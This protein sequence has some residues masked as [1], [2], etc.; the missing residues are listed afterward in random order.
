MKATV[1]KINNAYVV[2]GI[3]ELD[4]QDGVQRYEMRYLHSLGSKYY[5][6]EKNAVRA[7]E[8]N[9]YEYIPTTRN[10]L[11]CAYD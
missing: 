4:K 2:T 7:I 11:V 8:R 10:Q 9:Q 6:T 3:I 5:K 1:Q